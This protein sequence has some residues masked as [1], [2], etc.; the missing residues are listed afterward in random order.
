GWTWALAV[1]G[2]PH[3]G[4]TVEHLRGRGR[5]APW[6]AVLA[7]VGLG[8]W[9]P[10]P[11][12]GL[13]G[14]FSGVLLPTS[15]PWWGWAAWALAFGS[16]TWAARRWAETLFLAGP[17][18]QPNLPETWRERAWVGLWA[19]LWLAVAFTPGLWYAWAV[20]ARGWIP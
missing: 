20:A 2:L 15:L 4:F 18:P 7:V 9:A 12:L 17:E 10:W 1:L 19:V 3:D 6:T 13:A 11:G 8:A 16:L 5:A 14:L